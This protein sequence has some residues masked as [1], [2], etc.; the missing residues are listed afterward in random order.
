MPC[1]AVPS[2]ALVFGPD[3]S[4]VFSDTRTQPQQTGIS[5]DGNA[6]LSGLLA[7]LIARDVRPGQCNGGRGRMPQLLHHARGR[8]ASVLSS[9]AHTACHSI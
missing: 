9:V 3:S 7:G 4:G 1:V 5:L 2:G 6:A 8:T